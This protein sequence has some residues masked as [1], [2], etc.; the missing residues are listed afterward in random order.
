M[1][2]TDIVALDKKRDKVYID[3]EFAFV[4]YKGESRIYSIRKNEEVTEE[5]Y[6]KIS[7]ELLV[8]RAKLRAM[9]LLTKKDY[10]ENGMRQKLSDGYYNQSQID[11]VIEFLKDYGYIDDVRFVKN[12]FAIHIQSK[13]RN[14]IVQKL[15]EK[16]IKRELIDELAEEIYEEE[17][18]LT[19]LPDEMEL[20]RKLLAKKK[21]DLVFSTKDRQKAFGYLLRN[22]IEKENAV[23]LLKEYQ[24]EH[25]FT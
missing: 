14:K 3:D 13:T 2:V 12:Y 7:N 25:Y 19:Y 5:A 16:G 23:N 1:I 20:G 11:L 10:T 24:K 4:L 8:K 6:N 22:G 17:R 15:M 21:Y 18:S 9:N